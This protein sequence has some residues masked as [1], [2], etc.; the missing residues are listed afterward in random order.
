[1]WTRET[2]NPDKDSVDSWTWRER[3]VHRFV[4]SRFRDFSEP[5][6]S[7]MSTLVASVKELEEGRGWWRA[8]THVELYA[9]AAA[10]RALRC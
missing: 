3:N 8:Y 9:A 4:G 6:S 5:T 1:M 2:R 7:T 10:R